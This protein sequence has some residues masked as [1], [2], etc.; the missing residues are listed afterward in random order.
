MT[1]RLE[2]NWKLDGF[3][4]E[5]RYYRS[6]TPIDTANLPVPKA[7]LASHV[8]T[9]TDIAIE[10]DKTYY[11]CVGSVRNG[12]EKISDEVVVSTITAYRYLRLYITAD[13]GK[14]QYTEFQ[15]I[16]IATEISGPDIT[17][18]STPAFQSDF[19]TAGV[20]RNA[21]KLVDNNFT[22]INNIWT[23]AKASPFP[24]WVSFDLITPRLVKEIR[25]WPT[26]DIS[27]GD[28]T[29]R[30]PKD[31]KIQ[32]S[33]DNTIWHDLKDVTNLTGWARGTPKIITI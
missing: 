21:S 26:Y 6:K 31:F 8:R 18:P 4:D 11:V 12:V 24:R 30:A 13:N 2:L 19:L 7:V 3:V 10:A 20:P 22:S 15:E 14:D 33:N 1:N 5:Q 16:E 9:Y 29:G 23:S 28:F 32:G 25:M 27:F 17:T